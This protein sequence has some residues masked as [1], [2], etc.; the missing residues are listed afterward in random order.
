M[1][2]P[3]SVISTLEMNWKS[4]VLTQNVELTIKKSK[5]VF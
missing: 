5:K 2:L 3:K 1:Q 4:L